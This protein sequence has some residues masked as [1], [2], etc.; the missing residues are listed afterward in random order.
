MDAERFTVLLFRCGDDFLSRI[1]PGLRMSAA[2]VAGD[3]FLSRIP[4][5]LRPGRGLESMGWLRM[6]G[7]PRWIRIGDETF[8]M[9]CDIC[10][11][12]QQSRDAMEAVVSLVPRH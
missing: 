11:R 2:A 4:P 1:P 6:N 8:E 3:D 9:W 7:S 10:G 5:G 12:R